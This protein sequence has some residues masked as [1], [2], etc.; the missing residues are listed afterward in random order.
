MAAIT[1]QGQLAKGGTM[2]AGLL[3]PVSGILR[4][5]SNKRARRRT[6]GSFQGYITKHVIVFG[7]RETWSDAH[8][9]RANDPS[10]NSHPKLSTAE[11]LKPKSMSLTEAP[12][13]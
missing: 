10:S 3:T 12:P 13:E 8:L 7:W 5:A 6:P 1:W 9:P 11:L 4:L 2:S